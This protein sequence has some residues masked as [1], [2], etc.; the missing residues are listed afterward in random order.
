MVFLNGKFLPANKAS[1]SIFDR[2]FMYGDG[3]FET[4]RSYNGKI[5]ALDLHLQRLADGAKTIGISFKPMEKY[6]LNCIEKLLKLNNLT[7]RDACIRLTVTR[8]IGYIRLTPPKTSRPTLAIITNPLKIKIES[9]HKNGVSAV[10]L[11]SKRELPHIKSLNLLSSILG[12]RESAEKMGQEGIFTHKGKILEGVTT[13]IFISDGKGIKTPPIEDGLLPGI[14]RRLVIELAKKQGIK[15]SEISLTKAS[16]QKS[17]EAFLTNSIMEIVPLLKVEDKFIG[18][19]KVGPIT[20]RLQ[21]CYK[22]M[23]LKQT[24]DR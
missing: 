1:V 24:K 4:L 14:T 6:L 18:N 23:I 12:L 21:Q 8:G 20:R 15:T 22:Y 5:F 13:N 9:C 11:C 16:L 10:F 3:L 7:H 19:G 2:G 17:S